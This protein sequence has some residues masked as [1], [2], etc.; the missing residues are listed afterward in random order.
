MRAVVLVFSSVS[1]VFGF[2][3][4]RRLLHGRGGF[5]FARRGG[6]V[7]SAGRCGGGFRAF[8]RCGGVFGAFASRG[9]GSGRL[10]RCSGVRCARGVGGFSDASAVEA[11]A[12]ER[13]DRS[14]SRSADKPVD[15]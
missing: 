8:V 13:R 3:F 7:R 2:L 12:S 9:V 4:D 10:L 11:S 5:V 1:S 15:V 14:G 6:K